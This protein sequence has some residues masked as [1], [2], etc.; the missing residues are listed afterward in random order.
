MYVHTAL[1][2]IF[3]DQ[4]ILTQIDS[5]PPH[6]SMHGGYHV[7]VGDIVLPTSLAL[8]VVPCM[9]LII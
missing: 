7:A 4:V 9:I 3:V 2:L 1:Y 8:V 6:H 5:E